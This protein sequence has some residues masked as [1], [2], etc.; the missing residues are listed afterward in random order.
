MSCLVSATVH[1]QTQWQ[2]QNAVTAP[3]MWHCLLKELIE[4]LLAVMVLVEQ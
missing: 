3:G 2:V 4:V 1:R